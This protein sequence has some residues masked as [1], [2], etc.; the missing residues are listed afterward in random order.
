MP[1]TNCP[2]CHHNMETIGFEEEFPEKLRERYSVYTD[3]KMRTLTFYKC[4]NCNRKWT[5]DKIKNLM[6]VGTPITQHCSRC[7]HEWVYTGN[8]LREKVSYPQYV[9]CPKCKTSVKLSKN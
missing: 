7:N 1:K 5:L 4:L 9:Q 2:E 8:K 3:K 6:L